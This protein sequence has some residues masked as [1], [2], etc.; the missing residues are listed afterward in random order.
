MN[1]KTRID[2]LTEAEAKAALAWVL[3]DDAIGRSCLGIGSVEN[4][5]QNLL[6]LALKEVQEWQRTK[7]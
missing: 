1:I 3:W 2:R 6:D 7:R 5:K 4:T